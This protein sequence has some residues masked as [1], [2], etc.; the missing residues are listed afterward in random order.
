M[1]PISVIVTRLSLLTPLHKQLQTV[2]ENFEQK[3]NA[4]L[5]NN[6]IFKSDWIFE[7]QNRQ[8]SK[9]AQI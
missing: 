8:K 9:N 7:V 5:K 4:S 6:K 2:L 1:L 3:A